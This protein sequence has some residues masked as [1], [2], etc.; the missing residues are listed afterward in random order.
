MNK[1]WVKGKES[2]ERCYRCYFR[3]TVTPASNG[4]AVVATCGDNRFRP[5]N[6]VTVKKN[7]FGAWNSTQFKFQRKLISKGDWSFCQGSSCVY[8][9]FRR[10]DKLLEDF[11]VKDGIA[12][13]KEKLAYGPKIIVIIPSHA[14][15]NDCYCCYHIY[16]KNYSSKYRLK[17]QL[18]NEIE[19]TIIPSADYVMIS[20]GEPFFEPRNRELIGRISSKYQNKRIS[21]IT[22]GTLMHEY[23][24]DKIVRDNL[25]LTITVYGME[26]RTYEAVTRKN[27][28]DTVFRNIQHLIDRRY[29]RMQ[30][31]FLVTA[32]SFNE[33]GK[34]CEFVAKNDFLKG[35]VRNNRYEGRR[36][37][38]LMRGLEEKYASISYRLKFE[39]QNAAL[40]KS[41]RRKL[42]SPM[43]SFRYLL[44]R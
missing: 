15:N 43:H 27:N 1:K 41:I 42:C 22:N 17:E 25:F 3:M 12:G 36:H 20:G 7:I 21:I 9:P 14:C 40:P 4:D 24:L 19:E 32:R 10:E 6:K 2:L 39:Y 44:Q 11:D 5:E 13:K 38:E 28:C 29:E 23:G 8:D 37:W 34:F 35:I 16:K 33:V 18:L 30:I 26:A 31:V